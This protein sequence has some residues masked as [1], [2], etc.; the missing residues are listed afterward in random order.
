LIH[1]YILTHYDIIRYMINR[2]ITKK[3]ICGN[4][5]M[6]PRS[7]KEA[8][9]LFNDIAKNIL[10]IKKTE[11]VVCPPFLFL[12]KTKKI[13]KKISSVINNRG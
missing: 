6:N 13:S 8:E 10:E 5:K 12:E 3:I 4:W 9:K 11:I 7:L 1:V 2:K